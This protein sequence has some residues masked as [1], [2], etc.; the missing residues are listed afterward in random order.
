MR[1]RLTIRRCQQS[2]ESATPMGLQNI[3]FSNFFAA[4][5]RTALEQAGGFSRESN[6][7]EDTVVAARLLQSGWSIA[8]LAQAQVYHSHAVV[9]ARSFGGIRGLDSCM[10]LNRGCW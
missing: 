2:L 7:G 9:V 4:Y 3:C 1:N 6:F 8:N 10:E 5:R